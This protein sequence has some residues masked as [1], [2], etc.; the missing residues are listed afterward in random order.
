M[1][2]HVDGHEKFRHAA[3]G[4]VGMLERHVAGMDKPLYDGVKAIVWG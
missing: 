4:H 2:S 3:Q 1:L